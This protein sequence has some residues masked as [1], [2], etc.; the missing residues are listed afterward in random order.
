MILRPVPR[1]VNQGDRFAYADKLPCCIQN[2]NLN[3]KNICATKRS[4]YTNMNQRYQ[5]EPKE[6][7]IL[8]NIRALRPYFNK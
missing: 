5:H 2:I 3:Y 7:V 4:K 8:N 6:C 1:A